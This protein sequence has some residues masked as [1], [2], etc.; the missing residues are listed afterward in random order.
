M[1]YNKIGSNFYNFFRFLDSLIHNLVYREQIFVLYDLIS[2]DLRDIMYFRDRY[3][4]VD[5]ILMHSNESFSK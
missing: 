3:L 5:K 1:L 4:K 2:S